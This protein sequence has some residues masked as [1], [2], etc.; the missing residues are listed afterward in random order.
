MAKNT[1][2]FR[3][4]YTEYNDL[5]EYIATYGLDDLT[6]DELVYARKLNES[7]SEYIET[8]EAE[9]LALADEENEDEEL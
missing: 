7:S 5:I 3:D 2:K 8:F 1:N 9:K 4:V 6:D